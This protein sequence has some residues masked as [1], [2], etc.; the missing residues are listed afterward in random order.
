MA[1]YIPRSDLE[2]TPFADKLLEWATRRGTCLTARDTV[3]A[4]LDRLRDMRENRSD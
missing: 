4:A 1:N 2:L 3:A